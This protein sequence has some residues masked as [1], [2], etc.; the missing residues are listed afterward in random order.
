MA[1]Y[2]KQ[3]EWKRNQVSD[4]FQRIGGLELTVLPTIPSPKIYGYRSKLTPHY[5]KTKDGIEPKL[6][7]LKM[8]PEKF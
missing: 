2:S 7:F 5:Q 3:L 6:G 8:D 1:D 4:C